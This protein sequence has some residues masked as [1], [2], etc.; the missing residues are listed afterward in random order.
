[1]SA[2]QYALSRSM[3]GFVWQ[4]TSCRENGA[5]CSAHF[6]R[7]SGV[8]V[9]QALPLDG[10]DDPTENTGSM[11]Q[12]MQ[13]VRYELRML[14]Q[15]QD[16]LMD[17]VTFCSEKITDFEKSIAQISINTK[18]INEL[19]LANETL[20]KEV[21]LLTDKL[22]DAEQ[23]SRLKNLEIQGVPEK[24]EENLKVV[25]E[26]ITSFLGVEA[27]IDFIHRVNSFNKSNPKNIVVGFVSRKTRDLILDAVKLKRSGSTSPGIKIDG[28][29]QSVF[30]NEHLTAQNKM[31]FK[32]SREVAKR[33]QYQFIW[34]KN[35][36]IFVR[37][38]ETSPVKLIK[39]K[40]F[41]NS[42]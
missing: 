19:N 12:F 39:N 17:S 13:E 2:D 10:V 22:N 29:S 36:N 6:G 34:V 3:P 33:K 15:K 31:L 25:F 30:I 35:G 16:E 42:L 28:L 41:L 5:N 18:A 26:K 38:N 8:G 7:A 11:S 4:C 23:F 32:E 1:M 40:K 9:A 37:K 27:E 20:K 21:S 24:K 14:R